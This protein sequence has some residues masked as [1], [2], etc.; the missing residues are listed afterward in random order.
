M[1]WIRF[2]ST[3]PKN[4]REFFNL[5][6][7]HMGHYAKSL[8]L[9]EPPTQFA[10][11]HSAPKEARAVNRLTSK[12]RRGGGKWQQRKPPSKWGEGGKRSWDEGDIGSLNDA[13]KKS[14]VQNISEFGSGMAESKGSKKRRV[15]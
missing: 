10:R 13:V 3:F 4:M 1:S 9:Q 15:K 11:K 5:K 8:A 14:I 6:K 2:Y 12:D 7:A